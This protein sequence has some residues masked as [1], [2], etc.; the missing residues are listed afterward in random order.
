MQDNQVNAQDG[1]PVAHWNQRAACDRLGISRQPQP[2]STGQDPCPSLPRARAT[3]DGGRPGEQVDGP[4]DR[5][6]CFGAS[7]VDGQRN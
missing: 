5:P 2:R 6:H 4:G 1:A 3:T 7:C